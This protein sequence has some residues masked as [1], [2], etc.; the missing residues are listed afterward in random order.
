MAVTMT[1]IA[2]SGS[3]WGLTSSHAWPMKSHDRNSAGSATDVTN[4][5]MACGGGGEKAT[6]SSGSVSAGTGVG[7]VLP[8]QRRVED[9]ALAQ[10]LQQ[11]RQVDRAVFSAIGRQDESTDP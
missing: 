8:D 6:A 2:A 10:P 4:G 7:V 5:G 1:N 11:S 9:P 3:Q